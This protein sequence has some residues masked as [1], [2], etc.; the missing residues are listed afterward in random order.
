MGGG[1]KKRTRCGILVNVALARAVAVVVVHASK[2]PIDR[3]LLKVGTAVAINLRVEVREDA[4]LE[5]RIV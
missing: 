3:N 5:Q 4:T 1:G 2:W